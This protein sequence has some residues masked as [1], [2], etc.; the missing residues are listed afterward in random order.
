[1]KKAFTMIELVFVVIIIGIMSAVLAPR[2][3][4]NSLQQ[5]TN[6]IISHIRYTQHLALTDDKFSNTKQFYFRGRWQI[7][8]M[9]TKSEWGY[10]VFSDKFIHGKYNGKPQSKSEVA[11]D[12]EN[13]NNYL[14]SGYGGST[15]LG[16]NGNNISKKLNL[17]KKFGITNV[18]F[19][20][21]CK[22]A[23]KRVSFDNIGRPFKKNPSSQ[24]SAYEKE[25]LITNQCQI[26]LTGNNN[27]TT[28]I[29]IEPETGYVHQL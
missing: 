12:P 1:M 29:A 21:G 26:V 20:K 7:I 10:A 13:V 22:G 25:R 14:T 15:A 5:A 11:R 6:Q 18:K 8:F 27:N 2:A 23:S 16:R 24:I 17:T 3:D 4:N 9:R 28:T 19:T